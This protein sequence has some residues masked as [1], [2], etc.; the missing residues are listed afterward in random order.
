MRL[1]DTCDSH[2]II[3]P[4]KLFH[5]LLIV[6]PI[7]LQRLCFYLL[8]KELAFKAFNCLPKLLLIVK[9]LCLHLPLPRDYLTYELTRHFLKIHQDLGETL[10]WLSDL[11]EVIESL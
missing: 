10:F 7:Y 11:N 1:K 5:L 8:G 4:L 3:C 2:F 9:V 6:L